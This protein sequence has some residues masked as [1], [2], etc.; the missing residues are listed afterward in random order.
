MVDLNKYTFNGWG[1]SKEAFLEIEKLIID[2]NITNVLEFGSGQSTHLLNDLGVNFTSF[3][4]N[5]NY[6][7]KLDGVIIR[8]LISLDDKTFNEVIENNISYLDICKK[9]SIV[10]QK[11][12][13][14]KN[15]FYKLNKKDVSKKYQLILI[16][17]P[18]GN[19][20]SIAFNVIQ[21]KIKYPCYILIDD[22]DHYPFIENFNKIFHKNELVYDHKEKNTN[23][24]FRIYKIT[25]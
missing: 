10:S 24:C 13:R 5:I 4:D 8:D 23:Q 3:D 6:S 20:R 17:G 18:N 21:D 9:Y 22:Y 7:A 15:C 1:L 16:D 25:K 12:T 11:S 14:Q 19:G 2:E